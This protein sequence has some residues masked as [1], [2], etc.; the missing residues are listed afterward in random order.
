MVLP[1]RRAKPF[2]FSPPLHSLF[3][4]PG[5]GGGFGWAGLGQG[6]IRTPRALTR[7]SRRG[8]AFHGCTVSSRPLLIGG[9]VRAG[10]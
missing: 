1:C 6:L 2:P 7:A 5:G 10:S 8:R 9:G 4:G 3:P